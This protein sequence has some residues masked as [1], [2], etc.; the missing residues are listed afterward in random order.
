[1][2]TFKNFLLELEHLPLHIDATE[3]NFFAVGG[4]GYLENPTSDLLAL[5][6]G[7]ERGVPRWLA[8]ALVSCLARRGEEGAALLDGLDWSKVTARREVGCW[9]E[10]GQSW[11]RL[12]LVLGDGNFILGIEHKVYAGAGHNPFKVYDRFLEKAA[13]GG[14][15]L[16]CV[17]RPTSY[18]RDVPF[19]WPVVSYDELVDAALSRY[20]SDVATAPANKWQVFYREF[21]SHLWDLA[22]PRSNK[23]MSNDAVNFACDNFTQL[24]YAARLLQQLE[25]ALKE[26][27]L[28]ALRDRFMKVEG[29]DVS[30]R[31]GVSS[32]A[33]DR[34]A[35]RYFPSTWGGQSQVVL[36][37][38]PPP[39][40]EEATMVRYRV[41]AY[42][43]SSATRVRLQNLEDRFRNDTDTGSFPWR[44]GSSL[45]ETDRTWYEANKRLLALRVFAKDDSRESVMDVLAELA[46]WIQSNAFTVID[47]SPMDVAIED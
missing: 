5:F 27:G 41:H 15:S 34:K 39:A 25:D 1:M 42:I 46:M 21:L 45:K 19:H 36:V 17:L 13:N 24:M 16:R 4:S 7:A 30:F 37:Y 22:N 43:D 33:N 18:R 29:L 20:E 38:Y 14:P 31:H 28:A 44:F 6:M 2:D 35:L 8:M 3:R 11:K 26:Q 9:D 10:A 40:G 32:W 47:D 23:P 12:D